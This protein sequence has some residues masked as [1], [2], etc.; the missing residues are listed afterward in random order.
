M[1]EFIWPWVF[2]A[3]PLPLLVY[4]FMP[5]APRQEAALQVPFF[6]QAQQLRSDQSHRLGRKPLML[7][8]CILIWLLVVT[9]ASRPQWAGEP[10]QLPA[11]GRDMMLVLDMSGSMEARDMFLDNTQLSRFRVMKEVVSDFAENRQGDRMGIILFSRFAYLLTP[12]TFDL[13]SIAGMIQDLEVG[14]IDESATAIGDGI[15]LAVKH[16]R[17]QPENNR[18]MIL[19]TD[20]V[21]NSGELTPEQA[22]QLAETEGVRVHIVGLASDQFA[23][24]SSFIRSR[25]GSNNSEIDDTAMTNVA[26][27]TGGRYFRARTLEDLV[28][29]YDELDQIEPI[30]QDDQT[31]RPI[32]ALFHWPLGLAVVLSFLM[33]LVATPVGSRLLAPRAQSG[34]SN[35]RGGTSRVTGRAGS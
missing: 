28:E 20:G 1:L 10:Q 8:L 7:M 4:W 5:R 13:N 15:G 31:F 22:G 16:L 17:E 26:E 34:N 29:I 25:G 30:E 9:A 33:A 12:M 24:Q 11:T 23:R 3:L 14:V 2:L 19:L 6:R 27:M 21:N 18:V 35:V 32:R